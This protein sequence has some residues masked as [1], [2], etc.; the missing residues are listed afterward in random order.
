[1]ELEPTSISTTKV[2]FALG[3]IDPQNDFFKDGT[4]PIDNAEEILKPLNKLKALCVDKQIDTFFS[5]DFHP[6][7]HMSFASTHGKELF[8][9]SELDLE[10]A[11]GSN[12]HVNQNMW[13]THCVQGTWGT[14]FHEQIVLN[15]QEQIFQKGQNPNVESYSAFGDE[16][17]AKYEKTGLYDWLKSKSI[18]DIVLVGLASDFCVKFT[19][20][21]AIK[22]GFNVH[23]ILSCTRGVGVKTPQEISNLMNEIGNEFGKKVNVYADVDEFA[24]KLNL[25]ESV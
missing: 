22:Y 18:T 10:M 13:P 16:F 11:D 15:E 14:N 24:N 7:N 19:I 1:M 20:K 4:L 25:I 2:K 6:S 17:D 23:T 21:D 8:S 12:L 5:Q 9:L 3:V